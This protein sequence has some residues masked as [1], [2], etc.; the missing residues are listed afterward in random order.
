MPLAFLLFRKPAPFVAAPRCISW[1]NTGHRLPTYPAAG[2]RDC[3][4]YRARAP[5][6][7]ATQITSAETV[8]AVCPDNESSRGRSNKVEWVAGNQGQS[9]ARGR[10]EYPDVFRS[11]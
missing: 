6:L 1:W 2:K 8:C 11:N 3:S 4:P 5:R 9:L 10:I 7:V